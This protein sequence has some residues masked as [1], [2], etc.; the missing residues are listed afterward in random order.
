MKFVLVD[1]AGMPIADHETGEV[2][3]FFTVH[4]ARQFARPGEC[5]M[6]WV[7]DPTGHFGSKKTVPLPDRRE[8]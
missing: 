4:D 7:P 2:F 3:V 6:G 1:P 8:L 5:V